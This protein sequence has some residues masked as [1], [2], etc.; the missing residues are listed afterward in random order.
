MGK[1]RRGRGLP[2]CAGS[3]RKRASSPPSEDFNDSKYSEEVAS[4]SSDHQLLPLLRCHPTTQMTPGGCPPQSG[5]TGVPSSASGSV[6]RMSRESP[7][8]RWTC[9]TPPRSGAAVTVTARATAAATTM[10]EATEAVVMMKEATTAASTTMAARATIARAAMVTAAATV[11]RV[12]AAMAAAVAARPVSQCHWL[13][14]SINNSSS[15][16]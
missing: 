7:R 4:E 11:A 8:M 5:R 13:N 14:I 3:K 16:K 12:T 6:G 2:R 1:G 10:T 9:P 15:S